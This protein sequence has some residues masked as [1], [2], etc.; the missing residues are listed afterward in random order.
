MVAPVALPKY[1]A[2]HSASTAFCAPAASAAVTVI[3]PASLSHCAVAPADVA[4]FSTPF[5]HALQQRCV[6]SIVTF[7]SAIAADAIAKTNDA[8]TK[9]RIGVVE[10][11]LGKKERRN[12]P[13]RP[14]Q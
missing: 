3:L 13:G 4:A 6:F 5:T 8:T 9:A 2:A 11:H 12:Y 10:S 1:P 14:T 7:V